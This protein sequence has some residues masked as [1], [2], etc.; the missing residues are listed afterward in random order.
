MRLFIFCFM[1]LMLVLTAPEAQAC[2]YKS[3]PLKDS[4]AAAPTVFIG[5][6]EEVKKDLAVFRV[7]HALKGVEQGATFEVDAVRMSSCALQFTAGQRWLY[8]GSHGAAGSRL[9]ED[10]YARLLPQ[11][12]AVAE[13]ATGLANLSDS[14]AM[15]G[16]AEGW[17]APW[18]GAAF[19]IALSNGWS[20]I[21]YDSL[22]SDHTG[23]DHTLRSYT[24]NGASEPKNGQIL[25]CDET[26]EG[27][28]M[29]PLGELHISAIT[30]TDVTGQM[31][32]RFGGHE[33][34]YPFRVERVADKKDTPCG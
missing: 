14:H 30:E 32:V 22:P 2:R 11:N 19:R 1:S 10:Q 24:L 20:A 29:H 3:Q 27:C 25:S 18:D 9:L 28:K 16:R 15:P 5:T 6:V 21:V 4:L 8:L 33:S 7:Q 17:C 13:E 34:R 23:K 12:I 26:G 31:V